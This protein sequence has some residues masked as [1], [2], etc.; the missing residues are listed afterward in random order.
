MLS[1][2]ACKPNSTHVLC[3]VPGCIDMHGDVGVV[4]RLC[5]TASDGHASDGQ[6]PSKDGREQLQMDIK[7]DLLPC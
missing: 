1:T 4:G 7:G 6:T 5:M 3:E 2:A